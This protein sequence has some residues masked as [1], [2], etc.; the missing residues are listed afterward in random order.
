MKKILAVLFDIDGVLEY[1]G[2]PYPGAAETVLK[3]RELGLALRFLTNSTLKSR[4]SAAERL[5]AANLCRPE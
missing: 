4:R 5:S 2:K 1:Q 3:L